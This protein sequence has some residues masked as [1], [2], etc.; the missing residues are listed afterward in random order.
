MKWRGCPQIKLAVAKISVLYQISSCARSS[1]KMVLWVCS[2][3]SFL[4]YFTLYMKKN[5]QF[6][7]NFFKIHML[8]YFFVLHLSQMK[9]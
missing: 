6:A 4:K 7:V 9:N 8:V 3:G 1:I 5:R 2:K